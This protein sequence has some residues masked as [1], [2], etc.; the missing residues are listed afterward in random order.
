MKLLPRQKEFIREIFPDR[1]PIPWDIAIDSAPRGNG[2]TGFN[3]GLALCFLVGPESEPRG[4]IYSAAI[5]KH[6][7]GLLFKEM[8]AIV[9]EVP[10]LARITNI[11]SQLKQIEVIEEIKGFTDCL[12]STYETLSKDARRGH[13]LAP[14]LWIYDELAQTRDRSLLDFL[15]TA[16]GKRDDSLGMIISTQAEDDTHPLS[17]LIDYGAKVGEDGDAEEMEVLV[18]ILSADPDL[19]PFDEKVIDSVNPAFDKF[20]DRGKVMKEA[21][22]AQRLPAFAPRFRNLRLNQR[23]DTNADARIVTR[24]VW[25]SLQTTLDVDSF[26]GRTC[27]AGLDLSSKNDLTSLCLLF[28]VEGFDPENPAFS[29]V[30]YFWTPL[31]QLPMRTAAEKERFEIWLREKLIEGIDAKTIR[32]NIVAKRLAELSRTFEIQGLCF[33]R[34]RID[35]LQAELAELED[36]VEIPMEPF[37]QGFKDMGP[38]CERFAELC[39]SQG[40][41][42][43]GHKVLTACLASAVVVEDPAGNQKLDKQKSHVAGAVRIDGAVALVMAVGAWMKFRDKAP[44]ESPWEDPNF[45]IAG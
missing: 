14:T 33:D 21:R 34:W 17:Q 7:A 24:P 10:E 25:N 44:Q 30:P 20:L 5:D 8:E 28:P 32:Y 29:V 26:R 40:L 45:S 22:R 23:V 38:A 19:D 42:H 37:G 43:G 36:P 39:L 13:G 15:I 9:L 18:N 3:A 41:Q 12:G 11:R 35:D 27:F 6:Q 4:E 1:G 16:M 31:G 2:K